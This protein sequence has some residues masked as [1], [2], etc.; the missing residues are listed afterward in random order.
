MYG[1][2][3]PAASDWH[4]AD[5]NRFHET[6]AVWRGGE[7]ASGDSGVLSVAT[8]VPDGDVRAGAAVATDQ[9]ECVRAGGSSVG[10]K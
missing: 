6:F 7:G 5:G 9:P 8:S 1:F 4:S 10:F 2:G 3:N